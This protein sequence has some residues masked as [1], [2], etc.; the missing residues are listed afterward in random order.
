MI[1]WR[2]GTVGFGYS[3][4]VG[5]FYPRGTTSGGFLS[6][7]ARHFDAVELDTTFHATPPRERVRRWASVVP[8]SFRFC[9]KAPKAVTHDAPPDRAVAPMLDF[10]NVMAEL[11]EKLDVILLQYPPYFTANEAGRLWTFLR[12]MPR[13][14]RLAVEFRHTS[15][16]SAATADLLRVNR[17]C[18]ASADYVGSPAV[19]VPTTDFLYVRWIGEHRRFTQLDHEQVDPTDALAWWK[20][21]VERNAGGARTAYGFFNNDY[22]GYSVGTCNRFRRMLGMDVPEARPEQG[23][24]FRD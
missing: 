11:G 14:V 18:W 7:Y 21:E 4:W 9:V 3:D 23:R 17:V 16:Q 12:A 20:A 2:L 19:V 1:D 24:L 22:A 13:S 8:D 15:W 6:Y 5:P 10:L